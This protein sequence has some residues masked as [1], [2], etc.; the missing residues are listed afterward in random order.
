MTQPRCYIPQPLESGQ[1]IELPADIAHH[2]SNVLRL[3]VAQ[4]LVLFNGQ[5]GEYMA[6]MTLVEKKRV[7]VLVD[8]YT[9]IHRES[10]LS[11]TLAQGISRGQKMDYTIQKA[12]ELGIQ[13]IVPILNERTSIRLSDDRKRK[14]HEHWQKII[15]AA[16]EQCGRNSLPVLDPPIACRQ[17]VEMDTNPVKIILDPQAEHGIMD[18]SMS[19]NTMTVL[20][21]SEGGLDT[22]EIALAEACGYTRVSLG[23]RIL[24]T[25][26][27]AVVALAVCQN[28]WGDL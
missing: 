25:E 1:I 18:I 27:A 14:K 12:V 2:L 23:K 11:I 5:G 13:R 24:R 8:T 19:E 10:P 17:W 9:D 21:G 16:C 3:R 26:T 28:L 7:Q 22:D 6:H 15:I 4:P 20:I